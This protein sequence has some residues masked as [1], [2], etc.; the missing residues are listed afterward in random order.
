MINQPKIPTLV[1]LFLLL[2]GTVAGAVLVQSDKIFKSEA[3]LEEK[4]EEVRVTNVTDN[5]F[6]VSWLTNSS[7]NGY[8]SY[9]KSQN[10]G[11]VIG[12]NDIFSDESQTHS[13]TAVNLD[14]STTYYFKIGFG[15]EGIKNS[16]IYSVKTA[17]RTL[18]KPVPE[19]VFGQISNSQ[20]KPVKGALV[21]ISGQDISPQSAFT[22]SEGKWTLNLSR[23]FSTNLDKP[24]AFNQE[25]ILEIF[26]QSENSQ[27]ASAKIKVIAS[28]PVPTITMGKSYDFVFIKP[29]L[30]DNVPKSNLNVSGLTAT[31]AQ[32]GFG[33]NQANAPEP[34][35]TLSP[36]A[37]PSPTPT[38]SPSPKIQSAGVEKGTS[39]IESLPSAGNLTATMFVFI[40]GLVLITVGIFVPN[41]A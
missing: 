35:S 38:F 21:Y 13:A 41:S 19:I 4:A 29:A 23:A 30:S 16:K 12:Q 7:T 34:A 18:A 31:A 15:K 36:S 5:S 14:P 17:V 39:I 27:F 22:D 10:S 40:L 37:K 20:N 2:I 28:K 6:T 11:A 25:T 3:K 26:T 32:S 24:A 8:I 9:G 1:G 33:S